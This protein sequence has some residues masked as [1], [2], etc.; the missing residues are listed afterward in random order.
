MM[1]TYQ[2]AGMSSNMN[3]PAESV[4]ES[5]GDGKKLNST[6]RFSTA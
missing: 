5:V 6:T 1:S 3:F 2:S 4:T